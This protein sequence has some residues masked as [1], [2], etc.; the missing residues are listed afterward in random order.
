MLIIVY[1]TFLATTTAVVLHLEN[2]DILLSSL[3][4]RQVQYYMQYEHCMS[5]CNCILSLVM[6]ALHS[7]CGH[8]IFA[9][10]FLLLLPFFPSPNLSRRRLDVYHTSHM[11]WP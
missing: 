4:T 8:Y 7:R 1:T 2:A 3:G 6:A 9:L 5:S 10:W 11:V